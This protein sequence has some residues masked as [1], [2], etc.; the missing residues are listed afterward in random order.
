MK[1]T[2]QKSRSS[3]AA[4]M[5]EPCLSYSSSPTP[6]STYQFS[7]YH[8]PPSRTYSLSISF[9]HTLIH[10]ILLAPPSPLFP[11]HIDSLHINAHSRLLVLIHFISL[12][13]PFFLSLL[14]ISFSSYRLPPFLPLPSSHITLFPSIPRLPLSLALFLPLPLPPSHIILF[15]SLASLSPPPSSSPSSS[16]AFLEELACLARG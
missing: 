1:A 11:L 12:V 13:S 16:T 2:G 6:S 14:H 8:L 3:T 9:I 7:S 4:S 5:N 10:F 15:I